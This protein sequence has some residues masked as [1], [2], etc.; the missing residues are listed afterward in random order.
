MSY[1]NEIK[2]LQTLHTRKTMAREFREAEE[3]RKQARRDAARRPPE[4]L[5]ATQLDPYRGTISWPAPFT[6]SAYSKDRT[7]IDNL[8]PQHVAEGGGVGTAKY[9]DIYKH[10]R[11]LNRT[12]SR[13]SRNVPAPQYSNARKFLEGL[14]N[15]AKAFGS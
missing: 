15:E 8:Y 3:R 5:S 2:R 13:N 9:A 10:I 12:L 6:L 4:R 14:S 11:E 7:A 1:D